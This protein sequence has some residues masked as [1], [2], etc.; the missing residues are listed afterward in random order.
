MAVATMTK[1]TFVDRVL[2]RSGVVGY[3]QIGYRLRR[4]GWSSL[5]PDAL[6]GRRVLITGSTSGIGRAAAARAATLGA[7]VHVLGHNPDRAASALAWLRERVPEGDFELEQCDLSSLTEVREFC[8]DFVTRVPRLDALV[9]NTGVFTKQRSVAAEGHE[10]TLASHVLGPHLMTGLLAPLLE[11]GPHATV[12]FMSSGGA[13]AQPLR[14]DDLEHTEDSFSG[15]GAYARTKRM[16]I[17][18]AQ[19][20][21]DRLRDRG[22]G[23]HA[24]HPGW[25]DTPGVRTYL[26]LFRTLTAPVIRTPEQ[27]ADT[28]VWLLAT[29]DLVPSTGGFWH[30]R[31]TR[32]EHYRPGTRETPE[33]RRR[34]WDFCEQAVAARG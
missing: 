28:L 21:A 13:Y 17:V 14:D 10:Y 27:G 32:P 7:T 9:H 5:P 2:D 34:L 6:A 4:R 12:V 20:W 25:V 30:D 31:R 23:V 8:R 19:L 24:M 11:K 18:L 16:Q 15:A 3:T 26:T 1:E 29:D 22:I 33:Q